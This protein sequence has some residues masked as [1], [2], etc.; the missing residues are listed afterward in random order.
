MQIAERDI[1]LFEVM[2]LGTISDMWGQ[3]KLCFLYLLP[4]PLKPFFSPKQSN[5]RF[6]NRR[7]KQSSVNAAVTFRDR[8]VQ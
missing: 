7:D 3:C 8:A 2:F 5:P 1:A 4:M 6:L